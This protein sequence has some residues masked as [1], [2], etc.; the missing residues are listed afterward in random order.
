MAF[1][2]DIAKGGIEGFGSAIA[3]AVGAFKAD[4]TKLIELEADL[5]KAAMQFSS[6]VIASVNATMQAEA[7]SEH[8]MQWSWRP[9]GAFVFYALII[10]N[11][12]LYPYFAKYGVVHVD[13]PESVFL[14]FMALLGV[15]AWTR[16]QVQVVEAKNGNGK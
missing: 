5:T 7:K 4:P 1:L 6:S 9:T 3:K 11:F 8:W 2:E 16:G 10:N 13:I 12:I 14:A 15:A